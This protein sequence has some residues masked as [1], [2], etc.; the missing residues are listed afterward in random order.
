MIRTFA[1]GAL[2][3]A[4]PA[5]AMAQAADPAVSRVENYFAQVQQVMKAGP[6]LGLKGRVDRFEPIVANFYDNAGA[7]SLVA[8]S[9]YAQAPMAERQE[10]IAALERNNAVRHASNFTSYDGERFVVMPTAQTR[11]VDKLV[12]AQ[13]VPRTGTPATLL[14]RLRQGADGQWR[15]LDVVS[16]GVQQL[17]LQRADYMTTLKAGGLAALTKRLNDLSMKAL[18]GAR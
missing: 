6:Q 15:I 18:A 11:G 17:A 10:A 14:Y 8:G 5:A 12:R 1:L 16:E 4:L 2:L 9:A 7:L 13:I 3:S